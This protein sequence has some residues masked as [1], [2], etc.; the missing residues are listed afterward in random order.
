MN[1]KEVCV[2]QSKMVIAKTSTKRG[3]QVG[4][5]A[6]EP[7]Y[8]GNFLLSELN[9]LGV[10]KAIKPLKSYSDNTY[11]YSVCDSKFLR[12]FIPS[13]L[14]STSPYILRLHALWLQH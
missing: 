10:P 13:F 12:A 2:S 3:W 4:A 9:I 7:S 1:N 8:Q 6:Q 14:F 11:P 5:F